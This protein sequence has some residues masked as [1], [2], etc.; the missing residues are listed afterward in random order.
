VISNFCNLAKNEAEKK[1]K[2]QTFIAPTD[3]EHK[4]QMQTLSAATF[5]W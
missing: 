1:I 4:Y 3:N 5:S 2:L